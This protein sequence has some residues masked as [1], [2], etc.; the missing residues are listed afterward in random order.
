MAARALDSLPPAEQWVCVCQAEHLAHPE[1]LPALR[2]ARAERPVETMAVEGLTAGQASTCL[3]ARGRADPEAPLFIAPCD[4]AFVYDE[5]AWAALK[6]DTGVAAAAWTFRNH[7][8]A[9]RHPEQYGWARTTGDGTVTGVAV[10]AALSENP[11]R[12]AGITGAFWVR[13]A[14]TFFEAAEAL[15]AQNR[16]VNGEFYADSVLG[17]LVEQGQRAK[18]FDVRHYV[19]FGTPDDVRTFEYW[20]DYFSTAQRHPYSRARRNGAH[21][22][23]GDG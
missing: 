16:R 19:C 14:R 22:G 2:G 20:Q 11:K 15:I 23:G 8:H 3:L 18:V 21:N 9:N 7:P 4:T 17:V 5:A 12:D 13:E 10:K 1:L 6:A